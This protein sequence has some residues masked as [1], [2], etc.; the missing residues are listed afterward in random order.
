MKMME[1]MKTIVL[2]SDKLTSQ[3]CVFPN[4]GRTAENRGKSVV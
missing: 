4:K 1:T 3:S 2:V